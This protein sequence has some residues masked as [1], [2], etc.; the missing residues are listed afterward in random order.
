MI[1]FM[2][3]PWL[4]VGS[5]SDSG[6]YRSRPNL[7]ILSG[8]DERQFVAYLILDQDRVEVSPD[9]SITTGRLRL[10]AMRLV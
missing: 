9:L 5:T 4:Q 6:N 7:V 8:L 10:Y 3:W 1:T 2:L